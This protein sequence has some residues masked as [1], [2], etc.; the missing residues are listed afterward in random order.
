MREPS[1]SPPPPAAITPPVEPAA[2]GTSS[3]ALVTPLL[4][5]AGLFVS[6]FLTV[7]HFGLL[8]GDVSLG[9][10]CGGGGDCNGVIFSPYGRLLGLPVSVWGMWYYVLAATLSSGTALLRR[11]DRAPF[12]RATLW[13]TVVALAFDAWLAWAMAARVG[14]FCPLCAV[15]YA[16]NLLILLATLRA[17]REVRGMP[18]G[19]RA[20]LPSLA[21]LQRHAGPAYYREA[22]KLH[23]AALG[24]GVSVVVLVL[25][26]VFSHTLLRAQ[27]RELAGLL[28]FLR[29]EPPLSISTA[30]LPARGPE[31]A[32]VSIVVFSDFLC[33]QCRRANGYLDV[34]AAGHRDSIRVTYVNYPA[35]RTCNPYADKTLHP[36]AC[37]VARAAACARRQGRFWEFHD[38]VFGAPGQVRPEALAEYA[39]RAGLD[40]A[41]FDACMAE[42]DSAAGLPAEIALARSAGVNATPTFFFNGRPI[43]GALKP[44]MLEAA[45]EAL[46]ERPAAAPAH[47]GAP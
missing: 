39:A 30:G 40:R 11:E 4:S 18:G 33:E 1:T 21:E 12:V 43:V 38:A 31:R 5:L 16:L 20:L 37:L 46:M 7:M 22:L 3:W 34:V 24:A 6:T 8:S 14:R 45:L 44:W 27:K 17:A 28:E 9:E 26:L 15:T 47:G 23:L 10:V 13:L 35:D 19:W 42:G 2:A 41:A 36:G 25:A 32:P 29:T